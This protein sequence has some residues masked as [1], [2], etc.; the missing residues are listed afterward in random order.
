VPDGAALIVTGAPGSGKTGAVQALSSLLADEGVVHGAIE[1]EQLQWG[2]PWLPF[3]AALELLTP[4]LEVQRRHGRGLVLLIAT[5]ETAAE[6]R[7][8][9]AAAAATETLVVVAA[10]VLAR[11]PE[12][13]SGRQALADHARRLAEVIPA[14]DGV[15]VVLAGDDRAPLELAHALRAELARRGLA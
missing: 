5:T 13:W 12:H 2:H 1:T 10:R 15:D 8:L 7:A 14:L 4:W 9:R 6:L 3:G 11:E